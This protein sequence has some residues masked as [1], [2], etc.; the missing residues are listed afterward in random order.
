MTL[1]HC[2]FSKLTDIKDV[3][4]KVRT[5]EKLK[6]KSPGIFYFKSKGF[7]HFH[8]KDGC[9]WADVRNGNDWGSELDLP[10]DPS[11]RKKDMFIKEVKKRYTKTAGSR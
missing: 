11:Q 6:E 3:L 8:E 1:A 4:D 7:L 5:F 10:F 9:R 2:P